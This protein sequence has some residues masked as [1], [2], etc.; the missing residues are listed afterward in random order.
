LAKL[1]FIDLFAGIG[2]FHLALHNVG[3]ECVFA[4]EWDE[5]ARLTYETNFSKISPKLFKEGNFVGDITSVTKKNIPNFDLLCAGFPCQPFSQAG[6][7]KGFAD[8]RGTLFF[9]IAEIIRIKKP[10]AFFLENVRG[11]YSH[12]EGRTFETIKRTLTE[13]LGYTFHHAIVKA[14]DH[15]LPQHRPRLFMVGFKDHNTEF[16][17]PEKRK[18]KLTMSDVM[19]GEVARDIGFTLRVGGKKS[20]IDDRRNWDGY[21]VDGEVRRLTPNEGKRMQGFPASFKFPVSDNEA[22]KQLGNSVAVTAIQDYATAIL[23]S[24]GKLDGA[25]QSA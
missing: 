25:K 8:I 7:K 2:G 9:D 3:A 1:T 23:E 15:G 24:L 22:M 17:F 14:S 20:P 4:S 16:Q 19:K 12:D 6:F 21:I 5:S 18:L 11:L 10:K 13:D